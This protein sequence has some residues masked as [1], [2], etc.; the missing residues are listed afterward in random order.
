MYGIPADS[1]RP[2]TIVR[3][4]SSSVTS[5]NG[6]ISSRPLQPQLPPHPAEVVGRLA[7]TALARGHVLHAL[8]QSDELGAR[9]P[10]PCGRARGASA[11]RRKRFI[12]PLPVMLFVE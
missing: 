8:E 4:S 5:A 10:E 3:T 11:Q 6:S 1:R 2:V 12:D 7:L 9:R